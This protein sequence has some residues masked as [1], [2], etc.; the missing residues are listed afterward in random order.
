MAQTEQLV[1]QDLL[2]PTVLMEPQVL[3]DQPVLQE[4]L[5]HLPLLLMFT[6]LPLVRLHF[7]V[8]I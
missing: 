1:Q 6:P 2:V 4:A 5:A 7:L 8:Q 3:Q